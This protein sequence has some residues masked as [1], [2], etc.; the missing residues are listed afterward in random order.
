MKT[1]LYSLLLSITSLQAQIN[2]AIHETNTTVAGMS[3]RPDGT[4]VKTSLETWN[5]VTG[6]T[7]SNISLLDVASA[8]SSATLSYSAGFIKENS[9]GWESQ[10]QDWAMMETWVG[11]KETE[12][13]TVS[14]L[15]ASYATEY[16]LVIYGD[17]NQ[18]NSARTM[19]YFVNDGSSTKSATILDENYFSGVFSS[20]KT[21]IISGLTGSSFTLTGNTSNSR[22]A[23]CGF[24]IIPGYTPVIS[25]LEA[26]DYYVESLSPVTLS[27]ETI[28]ATSLTLDPGGIDVTGSTSIDVNPSISTTY[29]LTATS[30]VN[31]ISE[32]INIAVGPER[33]NILLV[34]VDDFG[35]T[36]TSEPFAYTSYD[37]AGTPI[38]TAFNNFYH[39]PEMES[40]AD[41]GMKFTQAHALPVCS[42]TRTS[43]MT[44][45]NSPRHGI[46]V[47][48]NLAGT[49]DNNASQQISHRGPNNWRYQ[50]MDT[51]DVTLPQLLSDV[52]YRSIHCGK[53]HFGGTG[54]YAAD[55]T[56]IGFDVNIAGSASGQPARYVANSSAYA[57]GT[58]PM[59][60]LDAYADT[61]TFLTQALTIE[62]NKEIE[63]AV[64]DGVPFFGYM[65]Y[66]AVHSPFTFNPNATKNYSTSTPSALNNNHRNFATMVE[67]VDISLGDI[68]DKLTELGVADDTLIVFLGDNGSDSPALTA[69][70]YASG[71]TFDD[72]PIRGKKA[73]AYEGGT[74]VPLIIS[75]ALPDNSNIYQQALPI[76]SGGV[77]HDMVH[78]PDIVPTI[79]T[80]A[81]ANIPDMDGYDLSSYLA[82][83]PGSHRPQKIL[84]YVPHEHR[85]DYFIWYREG[86]WKIIY[87]FYNDL[88]E[89]YNLA[90]DPDESENLISTEQEQLLTMARA[91]ANEL[92][93][94]WGVY[95]ELWPTLNPT[96]VAV[97]T[98]PLEDD[99]FFIPFD[100]DNRDLVD[101]DED[102]LY[103][104]EEDV[105]ANGLLG[106]TE[107]NAD[108]SDT[109]NDSTND[110]AELL[111]GLD[112]IDPNSLFQALVSATSSNQLEI[113]WPSQSGLNFALR[114]SD[115]LNTDPSTWSIVEPNIAA[116]SVS[117]QTSYLITID[118]D[119]TPKK[120]FTITL[121]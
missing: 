113:T 56:A 85:S 101:S 11:F 99:P 96:E 108:N 95:G 102:G 118:P 82:S 61:G 22:S 7:V 114:E 77:E 19:Q 79:L 97:P 78:A 45:F 18:V 53:G 16:S 72:F 43:L 40:L 67:G 14:N 52:G 117:D 32:E 94:S 92:V 39:T 112:P 88:F 23:I 49:I 91:M 60:G 57:S 110:Y 73:S 24:Q 30:A 21:V 51:T 28:N 93:N 65:A 36:D 3:S 86:D 25:S 119:T 17:S 62:L 5:N 98:R 104:Y 116:D 89:L 58:R 1:L 105:N 31:S 34:L 121:E 47:H 12:S 83:I 109:D 107:T 13:L 2:V 103:D 87:R 59:P 48:L 20:D 106:T 84:T 27:W 33:P 100:V 46:T 68:V 63:T 115:D 42:P 76:T 55:P 8:S 15:P 71:T 41:T 35:A 80:A 64:N 26:N 111:L 50:G 4:V 66:Y 10:S 37:D 74:R 70:G 75:W 54:R 44:G 120:F 38:V 69:E 9:I 6:Q 29:T 81:G 90:D